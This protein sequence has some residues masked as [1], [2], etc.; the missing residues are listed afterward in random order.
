M[1]PPVTYSQNLTPIWYPRL[2]FYTN[3]PLWQLIPSRVTKFHFLCLKSNQVHTSLI[4]THINLFVKYRLNSKSF[5]ASFPISNLL[6]HY[7]SFKH[8]FHVVWPLGRHISRFMCHNALC[9]YLFTFHILMA[10]WLI[11]AHLFCHFSDL[12]CP[13]AISCPAWILSLSHEILKG[14]CAFGPFLS[15]LVIE[16]QHKYLNV[17]LCPWMNKVQ[18]KS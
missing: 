1:I 11:H 10:M 12:T 17:N 2:Q 5:H 6:W 9:M 16:C 4:F 13:W 14:K 7:S 3:S 8:R 15:I 18:I